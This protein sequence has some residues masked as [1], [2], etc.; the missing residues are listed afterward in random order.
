LTENELNALVV[1]LGPT[2]SGKSEL[3]LH[4][5]E[6]LDGEIVNCD[7]VQVYKRFDVGTA[8]VPE[9]ERRGIP[10]HLIDVAEP[11]E[12]FTAADYAAATEKA[13]REIA[14]RGR[15]PIVAGG[16]GFYLRALLEGLS[17]GPKRDE[18]LRENLLHRERRRPGALHRILTERQKQNPA[19]AGS[20]SAR[21]SPNGG[22]VRES[23]G[24]PYGISAD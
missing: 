3:A 10:H 12:L 7:S 24:T 19:G 23:A 2:G 11:S 6:E 1:V 4:L 16:T 15:T 9:S 8:K 17:P 5:A 22:Y 13:L 18:A 21:G 14:S 20:A